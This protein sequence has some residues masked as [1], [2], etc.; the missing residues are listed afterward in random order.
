MG[1]Q[2]LPGKVLRSVCGKPLLQYL[3]ERL[4]RASRIGQIIVA[5][6]TNDVDTAIAHFCE[7]HAITCFRGSLENVADR[8][9]RIIQQYE[10]D[11]FV[12]VSGDSPLLDASILRRCWDRFVST[13]C[14]L[15]TNVFPRTFPR[16]QSAEVV[17][18]SSFLRACE[19]MLQPEDLEH[20]TRFYYR[21]PS[22]YRIE[23]VVAGT[24]YGG[25]HMAVDS[26]QDLVAFEQVVQSMNKPHWEYGLAE[27]ADLY[28]RI[29]LVEQPT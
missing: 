27:V 4:S 16:G 8:F 22:R 2:R 26:P 14:D 9:R 20:V 23:N 18:A 17:R 7:E 11:A 10:L 6:S 25:C 19:L 28:H 15:A 29:G 12:R 21:N 3:I 5:T 24:N 13:N 1:S